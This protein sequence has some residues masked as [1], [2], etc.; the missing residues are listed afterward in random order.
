[1]ADNIFNHTNNKSLP[2][3]K[4]FNICI[5]DKRYKSN[6][7]TVDHVT[8]FFRLMT[9]KLNSRITAHMLRHTMATK[10]ANGGGN[11]KALQQ[12]LGHNNIKTTMVTFI[13]I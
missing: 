9:K 13:Q 10:I 4:V 7:M 1:M 5:F 6:E 2:Q 11:I 3:D 8:K 12:M